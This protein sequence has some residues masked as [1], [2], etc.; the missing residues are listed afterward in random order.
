MSALL[1]PCWLTLDAGNTRTKWAVLAEDDGAIIAQ[2]YLQPGDELPA[3]WHQCSRIAVA[4]VAGEATQTWLQQQLA[5]L[6]LPVRWHTSSAQACGLVN[7]YMQAEQ[8]GVDRWA[9][10]IAAWQYYQRS[11][12]VV[13]AGT[14]LTV[15]LIQ[16]VAPGEGRFMGGIIVPGLRL[17]QSSLSSAA[18]GIAASQGNWQDFPRNTADAVYSGSL[19]AMC[20]AVDNM[21]QKLSEYCGYVVP[22]MVSGGDASVLLPLLEKHALAREYQLEEQLVLQGLWY[23]E[24]EAS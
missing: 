5:T 23:L 2:G 21:L 6:K 8:L 14:A 12:V 3:A 19:Q 1:L 17:M 10:M 9:A 13:N 20:G 15:D 11:C 18:A 24:R 7:D 16:K 22:C 4:N